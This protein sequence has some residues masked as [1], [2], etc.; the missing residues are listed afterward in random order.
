MY[1]IL[2][3]Y[4]VEGDV[5][6]KCDLMTEGIVGSTLWDCT[7]LTI[8]DCSVVGEWP[9]HFVVERTKTNPNVVC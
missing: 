7:G 1:G 5:I 3:T 4:I 6:S 9:G 8:T 2:L